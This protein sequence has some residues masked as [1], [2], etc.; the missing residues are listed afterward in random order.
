MTPKDMM[1]FDGNAE[2][3]GI[4]KSALMENAGK[5]VADYII[6]TLN[7][8]KVTIFA[9]NGGNGG[10]GFVAALHLLN[11][12]YTVELLFL[13]YP[14]RIKSHETLQNWTAIQNISLGINS[15]EIKIITDSSAIKKIDS[16]AII[17]AMLGTGIKG[18]IKEPISSAIDLINESLL[19]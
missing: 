1:A 15:L 5:S 9:G 13:G 3:L 14:S 11:N 17:D 8:C 12:E 19:G 2:D 10:D 16:P 18:K 7:P 4:S 6:N